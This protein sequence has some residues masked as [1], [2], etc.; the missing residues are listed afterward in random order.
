[1]KR[2]LSI[3]SNEEELA[4]ALRRAVASFGEGGTHSSGSILVGVKVSPSA[5]PQEGQELLFS[6]ISLRQLGHTVMGRGLYHHFSI[7][8]MPIAECGYEK[9]LKGVC[10][11]RPA[12]C[13]KY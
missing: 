13:R 4:E 11:K 6:G 8:C 10:R 9:W 2:T 12:K 7:A 1:V 3:E 5:V